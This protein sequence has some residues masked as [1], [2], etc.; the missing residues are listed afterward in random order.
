MLRDLKTLV[1]IV[2]AA[3]GGLSQIR[4]KKARSQAILELLYLYFVLLDVVEDGRSLL[5]A[6]GQNPGE[7]LAA[8]PE[9]QVSA[10]LREWDALIRRQASRLY[11]LSGRILGQDALSVIDP[12]L[13]TKL[14]NLVGSKSRRA[15]GLEGIGAGLVIYSMIN[16]RR[17]LST[18]ILSMYPLRNR[19]SINL[20]AAN[21]EL[22]QLQE[23]LDT[24]RALCLRLTSEG[25]VLLLSRKARKS[26]RL[27]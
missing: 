3:M 6:V 25:E 17:E 7:T 19:I 5:N 20:L 15:R 22:D 23:T 14:L 9:A 4:S 1:D 18:V 21:K 8:V 13:K 11:N 12:T 2:R 10:R 24:F 26:S 16:D 27:T